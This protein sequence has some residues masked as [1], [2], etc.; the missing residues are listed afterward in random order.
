[1]FVIK[2]MHMKISFSTPHPKESEHRSEREILKGC[3]SPPV[4]VSSDGWRVIR[5][6]GSRKKEGCLLIKFG[7]S[8]SPLGVG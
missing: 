8:L 3:L 1:M 4:F 5:G 6:F 7:V 2:C